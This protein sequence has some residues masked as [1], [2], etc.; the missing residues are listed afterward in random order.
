MR[1]KHLTRLGLV[2]LVALQFSG[3]VKEGPQTSSSGARQVV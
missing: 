3:C 2:C 1:M